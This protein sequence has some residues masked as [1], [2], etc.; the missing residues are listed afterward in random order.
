MKKALL[1]IDVQNDYFAGGKYE[2]VH[3]DEALNMIKRLLRSFRAENL[4]VFYV[5]HLSD[6]NANFFIPE[7]LGSCIHDAITPLENEKI[8]V[9]NYV[10][11][12][13]S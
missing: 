7:T 4:P 13:I 11:R 3:P 6:S 5:Q 2:L 8:I 12:F 1:I 10:H 9:K